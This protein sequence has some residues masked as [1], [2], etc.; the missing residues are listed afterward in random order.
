MS[1]NV[2]IYILDIQANIEKILRYTENMSFE[3]FQRDT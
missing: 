2:R 1:R 3:D